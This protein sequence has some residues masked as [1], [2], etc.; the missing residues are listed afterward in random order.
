MKK[1]INVGIIGLGKMGILH[2]GIL[3]ALDSVKVKAITEKE[4]GNFLLS[5]IK[6]YL[7]EIEI[8]NDY[9]KML[10]KSDIDVVYITTPTKYHVT[11]ARDC[12]ER[13]IPFFVEKPLGRSAKECESLIEEGK[14]KEIV[15]MVGYN[16]HFI[17]TFQK[18]KEL[19]DSGIIGEP[20]YVR[21]HMYVS[22]LFSKSKGWRYRKEESGGGVLNTLATHL[23]D[24]LIWFFGDI[25]SV[26]SNA[27]SYYSK[28]V[29]DFIHSYIIFENG[30]EGY[31]D[32]S[33]SVRNYRLPEI[34]IEVEGENG[35]LMVTEDYV[36]YQLDSTNVIRTIYKQELYRGV[37]IDIGGSEYTKE[38]V[39]MIEHVR[40]NE[41]TDLDIFYAYKIQTVTDA[42]YESIEKKKQIDVIYTV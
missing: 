3:N 18:A 12:L 9:I 30:L 39:Y 25:T 21:S 19:L 22:Q 33:W 13:E 20:V 16:R 10:D 32:S 2:M 35:S 31:M 6:K 17:D 42:M 27:K 29:E 8:Y 1:D 14:Q 11:M 5:G 23:V 34:K 4:K 37:E 15:N 7:P 38:N 40:K 36:K 26:F 24:V 28:E 41:Q